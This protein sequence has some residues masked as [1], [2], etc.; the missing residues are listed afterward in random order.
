[1]VHEADPSSDPGTDHDPRGH[2]DRRRRRRDPLSDLAELINIGTLFAFVLVN[3]GVIYLRR[4]A[5]DLERG[6]RTPLVPI[7][8]L[9][10][11]ALCVYL[12]SKLQD[13]TWWRF[14]IWM[15]GGL[16]VYFTYSRSHSRL[17]R[18]EDP[19]G[20]ERLTRD[21]SGGPA[22]TRPTPADR[23]A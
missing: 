22:P 13:V 14:G 19:V 18:G 6:F 9:I 23:P 1:M 2:P 15:A 5:P 11:I 3:A 17:R 7:F 12:M 10:G 21:P 8:P 16:V 4:A 20:L